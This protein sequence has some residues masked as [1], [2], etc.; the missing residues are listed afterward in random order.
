ML[1]E[2]YS[3]NAGSQAILLLVVLGSAGFKAEILEIRANAV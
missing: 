3:D 1:A 2:G